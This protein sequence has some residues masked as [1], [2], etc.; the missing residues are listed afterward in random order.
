MPTKKYMITSLGSEALKGELVI[1]P[2]GERTPL[3]LDEAQKSLLRAV[4]GS[5]SGLTAKDIVQSFGVSERGLTKEFF[6]EELETMEEDGLVRR[7]H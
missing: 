2:Y 6:E 5:S 3:A 7:I 1:G 4:K